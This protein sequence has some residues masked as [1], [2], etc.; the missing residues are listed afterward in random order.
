MNMSRKPG[1]LS[2]CASHWGTDIGV[3]LAEKVNRASVLNRVVDWLNKN[4][5]LVKIVA[6]ILGLMVLVQT[7]RIIDWSGGKTRVVTSITTGVTKVYSGSNRVWEPD[8]AKELKEQ[9]L[10]DGGEVQ[11]MK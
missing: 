6:I 7:F 5:R 2:D 8:I 11:Y 10:R 3:V 1:I 4:R 9:F